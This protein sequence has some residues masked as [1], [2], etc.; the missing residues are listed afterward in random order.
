MC[1]CVCVTVQPLRVNV[2]EAVIRNIDQILTY[3]HDKEDA[4]KTVFHPARH[5]A[6]KEISELLADFRAKR[7]LGKSEITSLYWT[8]IQTGWKV[9]NLEQRR[10]SL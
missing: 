6:Q 2:E 1:V 8:G 5:F 7:A 10:K 3:K 4:L 9:I